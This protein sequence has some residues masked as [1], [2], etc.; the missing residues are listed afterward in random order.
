[1][2]KDDFHSEQKKDS[3]DKFTDDDFKVEEVNIEEDFDLTQ[4]IDEVVDMKEPL[5]EELAL[6]QE[7]EQ[8]L[9]DINT[10]IGKQIQ[11]ELDYNKGKEN[12]KRRIPLWVKIVGA[13]VDTFVLIFV[14]LIITPGGR[15]FL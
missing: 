15:D 12:R 8:I 5:D 2:N 6:V 9:S 4:W 14:L 10:S 7:E 13:S 11:K 3:Y 1:M